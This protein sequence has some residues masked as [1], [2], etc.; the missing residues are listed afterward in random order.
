MSNYK[1]L[2]KINSPEDLKKYKDEELIEISKELRQYIIDVVSESPGHFASSLGVV[3]L[4]VAL[5]YVFNTP[6]DKIVWDV[7]H[8]AYGHKILTGRRDNFHTNRKLGGVCG[9]PTI[10]ES[11]YDAF[12]VG[13]SSTSISAALGMAVSSCLQGQKDKHVIA[14]IGDGAMTGGLAFEGMNNAGV[15]KSN[16]LIILNDNNM[17]IDPN[18]GGLNQYLLDITTS[19]TYNKFKEDIWNV[20]G[21]IK[22]F[23]PNTRSF[24]QNIENGVKSVVMKQSNIFEAMNLRYFGPVNGH[25]VNQLVKV[26]EDLKDIKGPKILHILTKKGKGFEVAENDQT[27]WHA[28]GKFNKETGERLVGKSDKPLA[29]K[30][31][32]VFGNTL[33][34]LAEKNKKIVGITPAMPSGSSMKIMMEAIPERSFDVGIAEQHAVTFSAGLAVD[35]MLP[36]CNIYS[37]FMQRAYDQVIHDVALQNLNVVFCLDRGGLVGDDGATHHGV[38]DLAYMRT[39]PNMTVAAPMDEP[40]LRNM[41]YTAQLPNKGPFS[42]RY[43]RGR[44][45]TPN[46]KTEMKELKV[47]KARLIKGGENV[48]ILSIGAIGNLVKEADDILSKENISFAHYDMRFVKPLDEELLHELFKK[49]DKFITLEDGVIQGGFGSAVIEFMVDN[50]YN[51]KIKRLGI[52]DEFIEHGTQ[53]ELYHICGYDV[54]G[55][56]KAVREI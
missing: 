34:E 2:H 38:F 15:E 28:P 8:Q 9:F 7:G 20:L 3:E 22:K 25:D 44:G 40:D 6:Y 10:F 41:M 54:E 32:D 31:Q 4:T 43:P 51:A 13:H 33:V 49:Y 26:L 55:I 23:G 1:F 16:L 11:E 29:P 17:S 27:T 35:G 12:G 46:W 39:V 18:V 37:T 53:Q 56:C 48:V 19:K 36:F 42:I 50:G 5:H 14:V 21:K 52:P 24:I 30:F 45:V 47:G